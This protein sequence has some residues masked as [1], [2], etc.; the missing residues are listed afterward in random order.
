MVNVFRDGVVQIRKVNNDTT[1]K[2]N[3]HGLKIY[4]E[5]QYTIIDIIRLISLNQW[6]QTLNKFAYG[7]IMNEFAIPF[8]SIATLMAMCSLSRM[9]ELLN[10]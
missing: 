10:F 3:D 7:T 9:F 8:C 2:L 6:F 1:F 4:Q 5:G